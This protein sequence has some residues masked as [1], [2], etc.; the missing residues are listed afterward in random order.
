MRAVT[1]TMWIGS[2]HQA[3]DREHPGPS[4]NESSSMNR[5]KIVLGS[6]ATAALLPADRAPQ[7]VSDSQG[8]NLTNNSSQRLLFQKVTGRLPAPPTTPLLPGVTVNFEL[9][10]T[11]PYVGHSSGDAIYAV[12]N[13][14]DQ[15]EGTLDLHLDAANIDKSWIKFTDNNGKVLDNGSYLDIDGGNYVD[16]T[17]EDSSGWGNTDVTL[18]PGQ[19]GWT[20][21]QVSAMAKQ[22]CTSSGSCTFEN[23]T[24]TGT[25]ADPVV[26]TSGYNDNDA[27]GTT[28]GTSKSYETSATNSWDT[29]YNADVELMGAVT[30]GISHEV[31]HS[32]SVT[33]NFET[34][35]SMNI[36]A[37]QTGVIWG[38]A[39]M[40]NAVGA[41][42]ITIGDTTFH[43]ENANFDYPDGNGAMH[44]DGKL[45]D[46][47]IAGSYP[48]APGVNNGAPT[49]TAQ[50]QAKNQK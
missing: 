9:P 4:S 50:Q 32:V 3:A 44:Y 19:D 28:V 16:W 46:G 5:N 49:V 26:L 47:D 13:A 8:F 30:L 11:V 6:P 34:S 45:Y 18:T 36:P 48:A 17:I 37:G 35:Y 27:A 31:G 43:L 40:I 23:V 24:T 25:T 20:Q 7:A 22:Y 38:Q 42:E 14:Q 39:P 12:M 41:F 29:T 21:D 2:P 15:Q 33:N 1:A 10:A